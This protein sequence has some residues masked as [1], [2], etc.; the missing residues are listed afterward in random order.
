VVPL[1]PVNQVP[2][3]VL[4]R[5]WYLSCQYY[6]SMIPLCNAHSDRSCCGTKIA[7]LRSE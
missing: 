2:K 3:E 4:G 1:G 6:A 5:G 7:P